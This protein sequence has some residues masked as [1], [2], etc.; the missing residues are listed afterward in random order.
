[1]SKIFPNGGESFGNNSILAALP[2]EELSFLRTHL[3]QIRFK[4]GHVFYDVSAPIEFVWLPLTGMICL[5]AVINDGRS[6]VLAATGREG[7]LGVPLLLGEQ[8]APMRAVALVEGTAVTLDRYQLPG[9]L[10][11]APQVAAALR[12][13]CGVYLAQLVQLGACHALHSVSQRLALWL[14]MVRDRSNSDS[15]PLTHESLCE[16][17]GCR[18]SS[19]SEALS[20]L[21]KA[22]AI[23]G[24]RGHIRIVDRDRLVQ[25]SCEC[26]ASRRQRPTFMPDWR[27]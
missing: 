22:R 16:V 8:I 24:G 4:A 12:R 21:Q 18:R 10:S 9:I 15:L 7:F 27:P 3:H 25:Q 23:R 19:I 14:L 17:L 13:Y 6:V 26:Y 20:L 1:M 5:F 11:S 2:V